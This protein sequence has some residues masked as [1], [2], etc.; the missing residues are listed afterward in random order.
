MTIRMTIKPPLDPEFVPAALWNRDYRKAAAAD[1]GRCELHL[2]LTRPDGTVFRH[3]TVMLP[4]EGE[5]KPLNNR[6]IERLVKFLLWQQGGS[7]LYVAGCDELADMLR[8]TFS[9]SGDRAFDNEVVGEKV[10]GSVITVICCSP[11]ELPEAREQTAPLGRHLDGC[12]IGFD[13]GGSDRKAAA[14]IDGEVVFS[15][16]I[17]WDP[18]FEKNPHYHIDG[19]IDSLKRAAAH[20]PR[21]DAIGGSAAGVYINNE[22]RLASLFRGVPGGDF[23][24]RIRPMFKALK[25]EW[26]GIPFDVVNDG[27]VT[28]LAGSMSLNDN[29]VLGISM[30]TSLAAGYVTPEGTITSWLNELAFVPVDYRDNA[31]PDEWSGDTGC[32]V[33]YFSQ[34][35]VARLAQ[36]AGIDFPPET[37]FAEQLAVVQQLME[38]GDERARRIYETI[39]VYLGYTVAHFS[40]FYDFRHLL[41]LG[42]VTSG[43][44]GQIIIEKAEEVLEAEFPELAGTV[45]IS[46]PDEQMKRHG[47]AVAAA[48]LPAI[49]GKE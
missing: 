34:Q 26:G 22:V 21:V 9:A 12:R 49:G 13:L 48:S 27:E 35:A 46:M 38:Q 45:R 8:E 29:A 30:G 15:E 36:T 23:E 32:G 20:L 16:E 28:A 40:E 39:G 4:H 3:S 24:R 5:N 25:A 14:V 10:F 11:D 33:Q 41:I 44:G 42:R 19:I 18:Y 17:R 43:Q 2:A 31:P 7:T 37:P 47:Q 6:Y 1:A